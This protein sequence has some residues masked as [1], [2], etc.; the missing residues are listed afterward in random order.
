MQNAATFWDKAAEK[1]A[2][3][4]I[5]DMD[6]YEYTLERTRSYLKATDTVLEVGAGT[7]STA[8]LL[9]PNV[10]H[11]HATDIS[12]E[13]TRIARAKA[14]AEGITNASF[15]TE[16]TLTTGEP[17]YDVILAHNLLH[18]VEDVDAALDAISSRLKPGG[19]F[20]SKTVCKPTG[21]LPLKMRL[22]FLAIPVMQWLGKAPYVRFTPVEDWDALIESKGHKL[23]ET[24]NHPVA[25]PSR[26]V[27]A[28]KL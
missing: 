7:G 19:L 9:A 27:V 28:K 21:G 18:L 17:I 20:V 14:E 25:P 24:G 13:M 2:R 22:M 8:L 12:A 1:Y 5:S 26:Y 15:A 3:S 4:P 6:A 11:I 23:L 10:A 16:D